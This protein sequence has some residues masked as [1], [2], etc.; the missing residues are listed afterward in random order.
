ME[1][2]YWSCKIGNLYKFAWVRNCHGG[3]GDLDLLMYF[4]DDFGRY[5]DNRDY[6][7]KLT[8]SFS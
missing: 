8:I 3:L 6:L 1:G 7:S 5:A 2:A 4:A